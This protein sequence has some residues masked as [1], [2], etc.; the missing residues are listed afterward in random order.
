MTSQQPD[1]W[2]QTGVVYQIY[3]R[4]F[5]DA[6]GDGT[7]DLAG[8]TARLD[9]LTWLGVDAL[10]LSPIFPSPM[11]DFGYDVADYSG[12]DPT[13][14]TLADFDRLLSEAHGRGL[15]LLLDLVPNHTSDEH[16]WFVESRSSRDN[17]RRDWYI[18]RDPAPGG[19]PPNN[20]LSIFGG[21]AWTL[22]ATTG[23][24]YLHLFHK[25]QPDL[26]WRNPA[27][28]AAIFDAMRFWL[29]RGVD[30]FRVDVIW[31]LIKDAQLR[32]NPPN[33]D[34]KEGDRP[35]NRYESLY[36]ADQPEVHDVIREMRRVA[37]AY[38]DRVL[39]GEIYLPLERLVAYYGR[40]LDECHLPFNF[41]LLLIPWEARAV[42]HT[43]DTYE[44]LLPEG[45]W[46]NWV[47][48]NHDQPR[49]ASRLGPEQARVAQMLLLT[50]RGTPTMYYGDEIGMHNVPIPH[51]AAFDP[52]EKLTPG[53]GRDPARTPMQWDGN[54]NAGFSTVAPWLPVADDYATTNVAVERDD[55]TSA[56]AMVRRLLDLRRTVPAL[57]R[58]EIHTLDTDSAD[59]FAYTRDTADQRIL[60]ALNMGAE[61]RTIDLSPLG[62]RGTILCATSMDRDGT[63]ALARIALGPNEGLV[64]AI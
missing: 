19:G 22:D 10:W 18:W 11:A 61:P 21:E 40:D 30:G 45:A 5:M 9:Y 49:V 59:V 44:A 58:G 42:G 23:Q 36:S 63:I 4:S 1:Q 38:D 2:W 43:V 35:S 6:D 46:P 28:R 20:W 16:P 54:A 60:V 62:E 14:G 32:D 39:I 13:F 8:I 55:P 34:W 53:T 29:D 51:E 47:I 50:L 27:V 26:N 15:K 57:S 48:G 25:K 31:M 37:D 17:P 41:H 7:G 12:V 24:Y 3:P 33:P 64:V 52:Q 56:L